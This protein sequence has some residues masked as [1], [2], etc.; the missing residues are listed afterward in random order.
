MTKQFELWDDQLH[1]YSGELPKL[2]IICAWPLSK[3]DYEIKFDSIISTRTVS[4]SV[5][6]LYSVEEKIVV[7][8]VEK[9]KTQGKT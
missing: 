5:A 9:V 3:V 4:V 6:R 7:K 1:H 8:R 2:Q